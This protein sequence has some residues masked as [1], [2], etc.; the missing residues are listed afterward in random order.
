MSRWV[1]NSYRTLR[2]SA[3]KQSWWPGRDA[4]AVKAYAVGR[5][6][7]DVT[8]ED[9]VGDPGHLRDFRYVEG[10]PFIKSFFDA[11]ISTDVQAA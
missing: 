6:S 5:G 2:D 4:Q 1:T 9:D 3:Y 10:T 11:G 8:G 7:D